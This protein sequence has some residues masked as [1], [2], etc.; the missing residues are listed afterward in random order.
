MKYAGDASGGDY[1]GAVRLSPSMYLGAVLISAVLSLTVIP[2]AMAGNLDRVVSFNIKAQ[3]LEKALVQFGVQAHVQ[4][5][6]AS[7]LSMARIRSVALK[8]K[9][10][11]RQ[12]LTNLLRDSK[13]DFVEDGDTTEIV[14]ASQVSSKAREND[15]EEVDHNNATDPTVSANQT[16]KKPAANHGSSALQEVVVTGTHIRGAPVSS[17]LIRITQLDIGRSGYTTIG[18]VINSLPNNFGNTGPQTAI[19]S[20]E[21]ENS[22]L[23][24][25]PSPDLYGLGA[26]STLTLVNGQRLATEATTGSSDISL[27]PVAVID[28]IDVLTGGASA[29]YGSDAVAGVVNIV[30]KQAFNGAKTT[31]LGGGTADGGGTE[32]EVNEMVGKVWSTGG[33]LFDY[34]SDLQDPILGSQRGYTASAAPVTTTLPG[35][36]RSSFFMSANQDIGPVSTFIT[37]LYTHRAEQVAYS[38][39]PLSPGET[40][41]VGVHEYAADGGVDVP[42]PSDWSISATGDLSED[43]T[44]VGIGLI[45]IPV[46]I[47]NPETEGIT[48]SLEA[49]ASGPI[50]NMSTGTLHGAFGAGYRTETFEYKLGGDSI[51]PGAQRTI[52]YGYGELEMPLLK[53]ST[54]AWIRELVLD[55]SGRFEHYSD[56]GDESVPKIGVVYAPFH[57]IKVRGT[58]GKAFRAPPL[59]DLYNGVDVLYLPLADP[60]SPTAESNDLLSLGGNRHLKPET[61]R[62]WTA[63]IEY[64]SKGTNGL[65]AS[66]TY[67]ETVY[68]NRISTIADPYTA[69]IDPLDAP[70]VT[71]NP[72]ETYVEN[73]V[74]SGATFINEVGAPLNPE[75]VP[76]VVNG[77]FVNVSSQDI[78]GLDINVRERWVSQLGELDPFADATFLDLRQR[79]VPGAPVIE[80][81]GQVFEPPKS[82]ARGGISWVLHGWTATGIVNYSGAETNIYQAGGAHV[83]SWTTMDFNLMWQPEKTTPFGGF[84]LSLS[85]ENAFNRNPPLV[86]FDQLV[87]GVHYD[88]LNA[89]AFGRVV[90]VAASWIFQ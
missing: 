2:V 82:R 70:F 12:A 4:I 13:W 35:S 17:P 25:A 73:L 27:I 20:A 71:R 33:A 21:N 8:G 64:S 23:S 40:N 7:G 10:T 43:R 74:D 9:Y 53:Q 61:A 76:A 89:N 55:V 6:F 1:L 63:G 84:A 65:S 77:G 69:L 44:T 81:S 11:G 29:I 57:T 30:L 60:S 50:L 39:S 19:G 18:D 90:R 22:D 15:P 5:V 51:T 34:E 80:I 24:G 54:N 62:T 31:V 37:G 88:P 67:F 56:F 78:L 14:P 83:A 47:P 79:I 32:R 3:T 41:D 85:V 28:H 72:S 87:P 68:E 48:K 36:S 16:H 58:W 86:L 42:L 45:G 26:G 75:N 49:T 66:A 46:Q 59:F 52:K 38:N